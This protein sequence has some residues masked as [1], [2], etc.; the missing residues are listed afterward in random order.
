MVKRSRPS[1]AKRLGN[2]IAARRK[3]LQWTQDSLA[4]R[5]NIEKVTLARYEGGTTVPSLVT[6]EDLAMALGTTMG[7]LLADEKQLPSL[8]SDKKLEVWLRPLKPDDATWILS[9]V[10]Q[11][12]TRCS[13]QPKKKEPKS[14]KSLAE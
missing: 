6:L 4:E 12:L 1:L 13:P 14:K 3:Q 9:V 8:T 7:E 2:N 5:L 11:L 10:E